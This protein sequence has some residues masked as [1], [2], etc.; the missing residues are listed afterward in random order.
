MVEYTNKKILIIL[1]TMQT[2]DANVYGGK[3]QKLIFPE[4]SYV[5]LGICFIVHNELGRFCREKQYCDA[6]EEKLK[7]GGIQY[8]RERNIKST[9]NRVDFE[10]DGKVI[11]EVKAKPM[12][13]RDDYYQTQR[14]LQA[15]D[16][17]LGLLVNF[18]NQ[19]LKPKRIV[20]IE[21]DVRKRFL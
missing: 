9:G 8:K 1:I 17:K 10:I 20:K 5:I 19:Y 16:F 7:K 13:T 11:L 12:I 4:L 2:R 15:S 3:N 14:Y 21:T 6:L 18:H